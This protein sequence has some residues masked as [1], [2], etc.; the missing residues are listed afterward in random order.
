MIIQKIRRFLRGIVITDSA[1]DI[2][3]VKWDID[4]FER[5]YNDKLSEYTDVLPISQFYDVNCPDK[6]KKRSIRESIE[7]L[8]REKELSHYKK[9]N[10]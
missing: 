3:V 5:A 4:S 1:K 8:G 7:L 9:N 6:K 10:I 2:L